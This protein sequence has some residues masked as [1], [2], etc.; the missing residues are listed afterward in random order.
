MERNNFLMGGGMGGKLDSFSRIRK[1]PQLTKKGGGDWCA[2]NHSIPRK[3]KGGRKT[4]K[5]SN[6][7]KPQEGKA[8][9]EGF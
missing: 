2:A 9:G 8:R 1:F 3:N 7:S 6:A 5:Q 4:A